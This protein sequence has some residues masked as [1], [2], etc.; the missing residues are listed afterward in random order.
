M[1]TLSN[2]GLDEYTVGA[3]AQRLSAYGGQAGVDGLAVAPR[4]GQSLT[5]RLKRV[6]AQL[7]EPFPLHDNPV[8]VIP[9]AQQVSR[10]LPRCPTEIV[11]SA[12]F[13]AVEEPTRERGRGMEIH[14]DA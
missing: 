8:V 1:I 4:C 11:V 7:M 6:E 10:K 5:E 14:K 13:R 3:F 2:V 9:I 12:A